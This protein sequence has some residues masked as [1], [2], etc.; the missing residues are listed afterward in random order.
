[1]NESLRIQ[2]ERASAEVMR[3]VAQQQAS[4]AADILAVLADAVEESGDARRATALRN[5]S[6]KL[7]VV[8][9]IRRHGDHFAYFN[10]FAIYSAIEP[11]LLAGEDE[12][13]FHV[14]DHAGTSIVGRTF[15]EVA[16]TGDVREVPWA[17]VHERAWG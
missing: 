3:L 16:P 14:P 7:R 6:R 15:I 10:C 5:Q 1:M 13:L 4:D 12:I 11:Y 9:W 2:L 17:E 8:A